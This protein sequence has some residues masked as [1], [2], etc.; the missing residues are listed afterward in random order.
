MK[1]FSVNTELN[2]VTGVQKVL[3]D[4][5]R[6]VKEDYDAKIVGTMPYEKVNKNHGIDRTEYVEMKNPFMFR[7]S[8]VFVHERKLLMLFWVLNHLFFQKIKVVYVHHNILYGWK[9]LSV[10][11][12]YVVAI[13]DSGIENLTS[14]FGVPMGHIHKIYNCVSDVNPSAHKTPSN[15]MISIIY[16]ARINDVK[17][18][19][20]IVDRLDGKIDGRVK[21]YFVGEGPMFEQLSTRVKGS[22][23]FNALGFR[24]DVLKL[25]WEM[26]YMML[27]SK[28]E[29]LPITLIEADMMGTP[30]VCNNV[31]GIAEIVHNGGNGFVLER[32][33]WD[34]LVE[35]LNALPE[36]TDMEY[37]RMSEN[38]R[39]MYEMNFTYERFKAQYLSLLETVRKQ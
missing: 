20:E 12:E 15:G 2:K 3:L 8:I 29:G 10:M 38:G 6:A 25:L 33:D 4:I 26:D 31:G 35:T 23:Q 28:H 32:N 34:G 30:I 39:H 36:V 11:P 9:R 37:K 18:Q 16:P 19:I 27:F 1:I 17:R 22:V 21:I 24:S 14:Y 13:S 7:K 5:H